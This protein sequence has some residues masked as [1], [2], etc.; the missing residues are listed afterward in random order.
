V[1]NDDWTIPHMGLLGRMS[2]WQ[3][4]VVGTSIPVSAGGI[5]S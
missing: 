2:E 4:S 3:Q 1:L 5:Q